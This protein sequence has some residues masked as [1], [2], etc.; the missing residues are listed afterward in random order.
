MCIDF[1]DLNKACPKD[2]ISKN[3]LVGRFYDGVP[4]TLSHGLLQRVSSNPVSPGISK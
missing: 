1:Q 3:I 2:S 4:I